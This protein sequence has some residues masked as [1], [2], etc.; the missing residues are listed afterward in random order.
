[1]IDQKED[2][3]PPAT[4]TAAFFGYLLSTVAAIVGVFVVLN[5]KQALL[6]ALRTEQPQQGRAMTEVQL[7]H[8]VSVAILVAV[9]VLVVIALIYLL[10]A[11]RLRAGRN[12]ARVL[13][14]ISSVFQVA[15]LIAVHGSAVN[16][17][18]TGV[19]VVAAVLCYLPASN[20]YIRSVKRAR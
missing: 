5:S 8:T 17:V 7:E 10:L 12:W 20:A 14:T 18:S 4:I 19:A 2:L 11:F 1:M 13:L 6:S 3:T 9:I 16:Y 15:S